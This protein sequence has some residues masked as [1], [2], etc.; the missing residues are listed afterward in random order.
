MIASIRRIAPA[1]PVRHAVVWLAVGAAALGASTAP[2]ARVVDVRIGLHGDHTRVVIELDAPS[3]HQVERSAGDA[4]SLA[5]RLDA[6]GEHRH[7]LS[8][9]PLVE[10]VT[11]EP[12][13]GGAVARIALRAPGLDYSEMLLDAPPRIVIDVRRAGAAMAARPKAPEPAR[14]VVKVAEPVAAPGSEEPADEPMAAG[15]EQPRDPFVPPASYRALV[16]AQQSAAAD[17]PPA[18]AQKPSTGPVASA[19]TAPAAPEA[20]SVPS[21]SSPPSRVLANPPRTAGLPPPIA[22]ALEPMRGWLAGVDPSGAVL[23]LAGLVVTWIFYRR[24]LARR[25]RQRTIEGAGADLTVFGDAPETEPAPVQPSDAQETPPAF[26]HAPEAPEVTRTFAAPA[27]AVPAFG[28]RGIDET[29]VQIP[30]PGLP[31]S[32]PTPQLSLVTRSDE[33]ERGWQTLSVPT[34]PSEPEIA[35]PPPSPASIPE[36]GEDRVA[37]LERRIL[38]LEG[39]IE[40]LLESRQRLE[41]YAAAQNEELR[42]QRA[43]I[44]RTQRVLRGVVRPEETGSEPARL[45]P[46]PVE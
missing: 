22:A 4:D 5:V 16:E 34:A 43:A 30:A 19:P 24:M 11:V 23:V 17:A 29:A 25:T 14:S 1:R 20:A 15:A 44:A 28:D 45:V 13:D 21:A 18:A 8:R 2:A 40:E 27:I 10:G 12:A 9:S 32:R 46:P 26:A 31:A 37:I 41:R 7:V 39:R 35:A 42:V 3:G 6:R 38:R 33:E 36:S